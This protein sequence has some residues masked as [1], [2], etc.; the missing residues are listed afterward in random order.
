M[1]LYLFTTFKH[2][3]RLFLIR[4][5][6]FH[7]HVNVY[8]SGD[9]YV[10][11][12]V[13]VDV[14]LEHGRDFGSTYARIAHFYE[15]YGMYHGSVLWRESF[16]RIVVIIELPIMLNELINVCTVLLINIKEYNYKLIQA[17]LLGSHMAVDSPITRR[18]LRRLKRSGLN[19]RLL[20]Q[21]TQ[22]LL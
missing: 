15:F 10:F 17:D 11:M 7:F 20:C 4:I 9:H 16:F 8:A 19:N 1:S 12:L 5:P 2:R 6:L 13:Q 22:T 14:K 18:K 21:A 3:F